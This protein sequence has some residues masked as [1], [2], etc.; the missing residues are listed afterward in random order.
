MR[1]R[2]FAACRGSGSPGRGFTLIELLVTIAI[3]AI[4]AALAYPSYREFLINMTVRD[5]TNSLVGALNMARSEAVKRGRAAAVIANDGD[6]SNGWQVVVAREEEAGVIEETPVSPGATVEA[7]A[8]YFDDAVSG[9]KKVPSCLLHQDALAETYTVFGA[10]GATGTQVVFS[11]TGALQEGGVFEF[12]ICRPPEFADPKKSRRIRVAE[13]GTL[14]S[15]R[16]TTGAPAGD[17]N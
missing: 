9:D 11:P 7:C 12:S 4:L 5:N 15:H 16:D 8:A 14:E 1:T 6:W 17:C 13:S 10:N 3:V 2:A